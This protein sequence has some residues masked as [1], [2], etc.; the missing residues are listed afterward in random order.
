MT[1]KLPANRKTDMFVSDIGQEVRKITWP[2]QDVVVKATVLVLGIVIL[3]TAYVS[4]LDSIFTK[5]FLEL[6][7]R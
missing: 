1:T 2:S 7:A 3:T 5:I 4:G 6:K